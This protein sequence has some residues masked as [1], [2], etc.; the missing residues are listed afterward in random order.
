MNYEPEK[1]PDNRAGLKIKKAK[2][3]QLNTFVVFLLGAM[4]VFTILQDDAGF[5]TRLWVMIALMFMYFHTKTNRLLDTVMEDYS[6][7]IEIMV[8]LQEH[9]VKLMKEADTNKK[10]ND[11]QAIQQQSMD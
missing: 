9:F 3:P 1:I 7:T 11:T 6:D 2:L 4:G 8:K 10:Q 5:T